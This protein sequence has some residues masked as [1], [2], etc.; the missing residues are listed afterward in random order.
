MLDYLACTLTYPDFVEFHDLWH[1]LTVPNEVDLLKA[2]ANGASAS[3][4]S[5]RHRLSWQCVPLTCVATLQ[6]ASRPPLPRPSCPKIRLRK[7]RGRRARHGSGKCVSPIH[8]LGVKSTCREIMT[9]P[10]PTQ[11]SHKHCAVGMSL[12]MTFSHFFTTI[13]I[14][15]ILHACTYLNSTQSNSFSSCGGEKCLSIL[16]AKSSH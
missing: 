5:S 7:R 11:K 6:R 14:F 12:D 16:H 3:S 9:L 15:L 1:G 4:T 13:N 8:I 2:L 10:P